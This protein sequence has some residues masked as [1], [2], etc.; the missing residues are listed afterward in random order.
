MKGL[1]YGLLTLSVVVVGCQRDNATPISSD[2]LYRKWGMTEVRYKNGQTV[3]V[4]PTNEW[5]IV[6]FQLNGTILYGDD[7]KYDPCCSPA[8]FKRKGNTLDLADVDSIPFPER[9]PNGICAQVSCI[10]PESVWRIDEL[11]TNKLVIDQVYAITVY[12][13][14]P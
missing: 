10:T 2:L 7:G 14:Y 11:T 8:R 1:L 12:Q 6:T 4:S 13:P 3:S 5:T 9:T